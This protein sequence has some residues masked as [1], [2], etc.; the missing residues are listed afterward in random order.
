MKVFITGGTGFVGTTLAQKLAQEGH[1]ITVLTRSLKGHSAALEGISYAEGDPTQKGA[2]QEKMADQDVVI[3]LAGAS[4][5]RRWSDTA[6]KLIWD[7]RIQTTQNLVEALSARKG[8]ETHLF[9]TSAVGYYGSHEDE[10]LDEKSPSGEGFLADLSREW[11]SAA[12][13]A[14]DYGVHVILMRFGIVLGRGGGALQQMIT[15]FK[16]W[17]GSP[18]GSGNQWFSWVHEQDLVDIFLFLMKNAKISGAVN[19]TAP[20][21]VTNRELTRTLGEVVGKPTFMPAV[22]GCV[23]KL[24]L[25]EFGSVLLEGQRVVPKKLLT[26]G[27][28]FSFPDIHT[29]L[30][31]LLTQPGSPDFAP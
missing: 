21:P 13:K 2:W 25:G 26:A 10:V 1:K 28:S 20:D 8:K 30:K 24:I 22:P 4:I 18:L 6:K 15:P 11:E 7:S 29:A 5:F 12:M 9:S 27:F 19:C 14:K 3:N 17:M 31:D 23:M 16:W